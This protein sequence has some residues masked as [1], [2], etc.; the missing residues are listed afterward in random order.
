MANIKTLI[1]SI[2]TSNSQAS[3]ATRSPSHDSLDPLTDKQRQLLSNSHCPQSSGKHPQA[4]PHISHNKKFYLVFFGIAESPS[5]TR[6]HSRLRNDHDA[7]LSVLASLNESLCSVSVRDCVRLG[8]FSQNHVRPRPVLV[9]FNSAKD[10]S[11]ILSKKFKLHS[12]KSPSKS[13]SIKCDLSKEERH[14]ETVLLMERRRLIDEGTDRKHIKIQGN[15][16]FV[17][18]KPIG[19]ATL[20]GFSAFSTLG[21]AAPSLLDLAESVHHST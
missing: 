10:V 3:S 2:K 5:G 6:Y 8:K 4:Q 7:I 21:D 16:I 1:S 14:L 15:R 17:K 19:I 11:A 20:S 9:K 12:S 18:A 13:I